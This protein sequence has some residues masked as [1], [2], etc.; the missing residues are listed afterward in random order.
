MQG[1]GCGSHRVVAERNCAVR[2]GGIQRRMQLALSPQLIGQGPVPG[3]HGQQRPGIVVVA[4]NAGAGLPQQAYVAHQQV[5]H[6]PVAMAYQ[7]YESSGQGSEISDPLDIA[8]TSHEGASGMHG[9]PCTMHD[10][11]DDQAACEAL[12]MPCQAC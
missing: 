9:V 1:C 6:L 3:S 2:G 4:R 12:R 7:S 10:L 5:R 8:S 11:L